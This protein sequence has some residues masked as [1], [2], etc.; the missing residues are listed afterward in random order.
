MLLSKQISGKIRPISH[1]NEEGNKMSNNSKELSN[2]KSTGGLGTHFENRVQTSF[3]VLMLTDGFA[4]CLPTWPITKIKL[5]GRYLNYETDDL[6]VYAKNPTNGKEAKL[7]GQ[8]KHRVSITNSNKEFSDVLQAAW[9]DFNNPKIFTEEK[10]VIALITGPLSEIDT[11]HV[12]DLL[13]QAKHAEDALDFRNRID[14]GKFT[15]QEQRD[16]LKVFEKLLRNANND[17]D[18]TP[19][20][21]WR[22]L[23]RFH[24]L[25]YDLDIKGITLSLLHS[26]IRQFS[27]E[28]PT[29]IWS[30]LYEHIGWE[31]ENAG[32]ITIDSI[33]DDLKSA[34][35]K[36]VPELIPTDLVRKPFYQENVDWNQ[37][38]FASELAIANLLGSWNEKYEADK[39]IVGQ[40][41]RE[42][43]SDWIA[44][45]RKILQEPESPLSL[46]NGVW[47]IIKR[48]E[49]WRTLGSQLFDDDL[50]NFKQHV[51]TVLGERDPQFDLVPEERY[52][53]TVK[54]KTLKHSHHLR[55]GLAE[56]LAILRNYPETLIN[57]SINKPESIVA[58]AVSEIFDNADWVL[59]G[60]LRDLLPLLAEASPEEF[61]KAVEVALQKTPCPFDTLFAQE[62]DGFGGGNYISGLLWALETLAWDEEHLVR[63]S[64]ILGD[65]TSRDPGGIWANR[66]VNS[67]TT[68]F[69]PWLPQT[70]ATLEKRKIAIKTLKA[71]FPEVAWKLLISLLPN[72]RQMSM[73]SRKPIWHE[74]IHDERTSKVTSQEYW[75]QISS[76]AG[77]AVEMAKEDIDKLNELIEHLDSL[78]QEYFTAILEFLASTEITSKSENER[79]PLWNNLVKFTLQHKKHAGM[80]W[81]LSSELVEKIDKVA[82]KIAPINPLNLYQSLFSG[83]DFELYNECKDFEEQQRE[84]KALKQKAVSE[85]ITNMGFE[86][87]LELTKV[88]KS[89]LEVGISLGFVAVDEVDDMVLPNFLDK[90]SG[91]LNQF[92]CGFVRGRYFSRGWKWVDK[93][94][95]RQWTPSQIG[96]FLSCLPFMLETWK[97]S[98]KL[99]REDESYYW[100]KADAKPYKVDENLELAI[101]SLIKYGKSLEAISCLYIMHH[102]KQSF[103]NKRAVDV[104]LA[105]LDSLENAHIDQYEMDKYEIIDIIKALQDDP[106]T[107][108]EDLFRIEWAYLPLLNRYNDASPK[109][110]ERRLADNPGFFCEVIRLV[111]RS[112]NEKQKIEETEQ[113]KRVAT[114]AYRLL[115]EWRTPPGCLQDG[116]YDGEAL[117]VWLEAV[118]KDCIETGHF[119]VAMSTIGQVLIYTPADPD[120]LWIHKSAANELNKEDAD[121]MRNGFRIGLYN[122]RGV[123]D[124]SNGK[125]E[126]KL[127]GKYRSQAEAVENEGFFRLAIALRELAISYEHE[128]KRESYAD[129]LEG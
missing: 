6:I 88:V 16:K 56:S 85:I 97:R 35:Q 43:F 98:K 80:E 11:I 29:S 38:Q 112:K 129:P 119:E 4:P 27:E 60:S 31:C 72:Q 17:T 105:A 59:W 8:I 30:Q 114:N 90:E 15:S 34:F 46:K 20:Q 62:E 100:T 82:E 89:P 124:F 36:R 70:K 81:A 128:A 3:V 2:P 10:D 66:P 71:E 1:T 93:I 96:Q 87:I 122:S 64:V 57:C 41:V 102:S 73:G 84:L 18:L 47:N 14:L 19:D 45:M 103:S 5:Q 32:V 58:L 77:I 26:L 118:K 108:Q 25:I 86:K 49:L 37:N 39:T 99:L 63:V 104:L 116:N 74:T 111:F 121:A 54:G 117:S 42:E 33:P 125:E 120:G 92:V 40:L 55:K 83:N 24:L 95:T 51:V 123:H 109:L 78:P 94:N 67:L 53:A 52:L 107:D 12:R 101:D 9:N 68:I 127:A 91:Y 76:Y 13:G 126:Q 69:L 22:F 79:L 44:K 48:Q 115:S 21:L 65:L 61:L 7:L 106:K 28:K 113:T 23:K 110:L 75:N 50:N